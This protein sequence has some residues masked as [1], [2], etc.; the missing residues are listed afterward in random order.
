M[1]SHPTSLILPF[2]LLLGLTSYLFPPGLTTEVLYTYVISTMLVAYI[3]PF[4]QPDLI[5]LIMFVE[6]YKL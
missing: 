2:Y 6:E 1:P 3:A 5:T 4:I